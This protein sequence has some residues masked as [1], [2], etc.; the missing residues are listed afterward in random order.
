[1]PPT[2]VTPPP[3]LKE[4]AASNIGSSSGNSSSGIKFVPYNS[5][6]PEFDEGRNKFRH[7]REKNERNCRDTSDTAQL[8]K[9]LPRDQPANHRSSNEWNNN[10]SFPKNRE[11]YPRRHSGNS[12]IEGFRKLS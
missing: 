8:R 9:P 7:F 11:T 10:N 5:K 2:I 1:M 3:S 12:I 6:K 4:L